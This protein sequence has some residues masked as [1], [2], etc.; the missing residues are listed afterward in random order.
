MAAIPP[1]THL[2]GLVRS[3]EEGVHA[4]FRK[5]VKYGRYLEQ[6]ERLAEHA[7]SPKW[8][9]VEESL[10]DA[11]LA[12]LGYGI[13]SK[14]YGEYDPFPAVH[15]VYTRGED[16][17]WFTF[18]NDEYVAVTHWMPLPEPPEDEREE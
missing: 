7:N 4:D 17:G 9:S 1:N 3:I 10:P 14:R 2:D 15:V 18:W 16:E 12:V 5:G 8:I 11:K 6:Q 13:R